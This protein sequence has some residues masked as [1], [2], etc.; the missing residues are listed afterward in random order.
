[1]RIMLNILANN[2]FP[3]FL[4]V[5]LGYMSAKKFSM[6]IG[7]LTKINFYLLVPS[8][9]FV[10]LY[11]T[12]IPLEMLK[13][14][15]AAVI[16]MIVNTG[17]AS[18]LSK[19][20]KFDSGMKYA[21]INSVIFY[22]SGNIGIPLI[23]LIFSRPPFIIDGQTPFL[24]AALTA[25]IMVL[26]VQNITTNTLGFFNAGKAKMKWKDSL[27][28]IFKMPAVYMIPSAFL[29][30]ALPLDLTKMPF[31]PA[32]EYLRNALVATALIIL[33]IQLA[34]TKLHKPDQNILLSSV[35][36][37]LGGPLLALGVIFLLKLEGIPAQVTLISS[38]V[39]T[40]V[41]TALIAVEY[42]NYPD[43]ASRAVLYSTVLCTA[44]LPF[45]IYLA[46]TLF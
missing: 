37:L 3:I 43:F 11:S 16:I 8:F 36:R 14:L 46:Q 41:N 38:S 19:F 29:L 39:P 2:I 34:R 13:V 5:G 35:L 7:T 10:Y 31:W 33:G 18:L 23:T 44:T 30:K 28:K 27:K 42:K 45:I 17:A 12:P 1:M 40:A 22:N 6:D 25:Q 9:T 21:F 32:L 26:T 15:A 4:L 24:N 20:R